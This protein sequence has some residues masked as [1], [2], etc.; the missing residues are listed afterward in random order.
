[1]EKDSKKKKS[2][3][4][5][6]LKIVIAVI[7]FF[8]VSSVAFT[9][10]FF[11]AMYGR[12]DGG[13]RMRLSYEDIDGESYPRETFTFRSGGNDLTAYYYPP[14]DDSEHPDAMVVVVNGM[15]NN[16]DTHLPEIMIFHDAGFSVL[17]FDAT[18]VGSS[19]GSGTM[20][21]PQVT[22]D[23]F[24]LLSFI[25]EDG[26][27]SRMTL[28]LYG[29]S[30]GG[31]AVLE[32]LDGGFG[33]RGAVSIAAF[34]SA[35]DTMIYHARKYAGIMADIESPF[36]RLY[37]RMVFGQDAFDEAHEA[38][39]SSDVPVLIVEGSCDTTVPFGIG[40]IQYLLDESRPGVS[41]LVVSDSYREEHMT[42][43]KDGESALYAKENA[44]SDDVDLFMANR[45]DESFMNMILV[46]FSAGIP[47]D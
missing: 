13:D 22:K 10:I 29:H 14:S 7:A 17:T 33:I 5:V 1:M 42:I 6:I 40:T 18:G 36:M 16:A 41:T 27:F 46:F 15:K 25:R 23:L 37:M 24:A 8:L 2:A 39:L 38:V 21:L 9:L 3:G 11:A 26:R 34:D 45:A 19:C 35:V 4:R 47:A 43:W 12:T 44:D 31:H 32:A 30:A 28:F 20:G